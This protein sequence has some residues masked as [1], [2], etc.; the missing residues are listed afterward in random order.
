MIPFM[1]TAATMKRNKGIE[2]LGGQITFPGIN[3]MNKHH[4]FWAKISSTLTSKTDH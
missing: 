1:S 4:F 2:A 3:I